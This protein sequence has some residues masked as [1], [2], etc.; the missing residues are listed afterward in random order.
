M[1]TMNIQATRATVHPTLSS[2]LASKPSIILDWET[3][4]IQASAEVLS[5]GIAVVD[6]NQPEGMLRIVRQ[7]WWNFETKDSGTGE[8]SDRTRS[9]ETYRWWMDMERYEQ[10][11]SMMDNQVTVARGMEELGEVI[12]K[13]TGQGQGYFLWGNG[14]DFDLA[15][16]TS[17]MQQYGVKLPG[18]SYRNYRCL[19]TMRGLYP[20]VQIPSMDELHLMPHVAMDDA[21]YEAHWLCALYDYLCEK[22]ETGGKP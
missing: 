19:R 3:L 4:D 12:E 10:W 17:V 7:D 21:E 11:R 1:S 22:E 6:L 13:Y 5:L 9:V 15:I 20:G 16:L 18:F 14:A 2:L 8:Q